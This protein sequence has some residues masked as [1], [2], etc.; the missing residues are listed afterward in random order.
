MIDWSRSIPLTCIRCEAAIAANTS[1]V[2]ASAIGSGPSEAM[3]GTV[4]GSLTT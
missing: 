4:A 1:R 2:K 3:P